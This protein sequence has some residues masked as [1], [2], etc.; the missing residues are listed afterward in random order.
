MKL[1]VDAN[2]LFSLINPQSFTSR[3]IEN[4]ELELFSP[5]YALDELSKHKGEIISKTKISSFKEAIIRLKKV[6]TFIKIEDF[7]N[8]LSQ[9]QHLIRDEKDIIYLALAK[10]LNLPIW[11][12]DTD[13]K[14]QSVVPVFTTSEIIELM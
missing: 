13:L 9:V 6:V 12:N 11:S 4:R 3:L 14:E 7:S 1:I 10:H 5:E 2:I 8:N